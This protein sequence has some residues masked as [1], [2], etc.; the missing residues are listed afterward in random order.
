VGAI[1]AEVGP[2]QECHYCRAIAGTARGWIGGEARYDLASPAPRCA[3][4]WRYI[5]A[6]CDRPAHFMSTALCPERGEPFCRWCSRGT[7]LL[8]GRFDAWDYAFLYRSP[9][10]G[11]WCPSLDR[12]QFDTRDDPGSRWAGVLAEFVSSELFL[13]G[14]VDLRTTPL[15]ADLDERQVRSAWDRNAHQWDGEIADA[16]DEARRDRTDP[17]VLDW[18]GTIDGTDVLDLGCGNGYLSTKLATAG[19]ST[20]GV[21]VSGEML[22]LA[23]T[24]ATG[25]CRR[26][27]FVLGS[28]LAV[29]LTGRSFDSIVANYLLSSIDDLDAA[30]REIH[31]LLRR[32]GRAIVVIPHPCFSSGP[33]RWAL[34]PP[35]SPRMEE[36]VGYVVDHYLVSHSTVW[37]DW[38]GF[39]P[40][41]YVHRPLSVYWSSFARAGFTVVDFD[42]PDLT[43]KRQESLPPSQVRHARRVPPAC[44]FLLSKQARRTT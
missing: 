24:R 25:N 15:D 39:G 19:A 35:D 28:A 13:G 33:R 26:S 10:S 41:P 8:H 1:G 31:R 29:P 12:L 22:A 43:S 11:D 38:T 21:D 23:S 42:E 30:L 37:L 17:L 20:V 14:A 36:V 34:M 5:C 32:G 44:A 4:H 6:K 18:L 2:A 3:L 9:W 40:I 27:I 16:G 7:D